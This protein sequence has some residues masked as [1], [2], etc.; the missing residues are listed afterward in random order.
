MFQ[1]RAWANVLSLPETHS[2]GWHIPMFQVRAWANVLSL[3]ETHSTVTAGQDDTQQCL[4][5]WQW[6]NVLSLPETHSTVTAGQDD[7]QQCLKYWQWA[8]VLSLPETHSTVTAGQDDTQQCLKYWQWANVL[9]LPE[10][11]STVTAGQD[12]TQQ[13]L[14]YW[15][16]ANVLSLPE[17]HSTVTAGQDDTQQCLK[18]WQWA[19]VL[20]LP[21]T[22]STVTAGQDDTQQCLKYWQWANVLSLPE[23]QSAVTAR[24][25]RSC[26]EVYLKHIQQD[27]T[28]QC[29]K[30]RW[31]NLL[32]L[33]ET[34]SAGQ[35]IAM[36]QVPAWVNVLSL[37]ETQSAVTARR[38]RSCS[39]VYLKHS[40]QWLPE[41]IEVVLKFTWNTVSSDCQKV[42][43]LFWSLP[44]T[45][46]A[47]TARRYRSCS[48][49]YLKH[50]QQWPNVFTSTVSSTGV[51][52]FIEFTWNTVSSD[53]MY[54]RPLF[55][56][57]EWADSLSLPET[58]SAVTECIYVHCFKYWS[59]LIHWVYLKHSQQWL[60][61]G[62]EV[63][64]KFT[65]NTVS[66]DCQKVSKLLRGVS[67][68]KLNLPP[69]SCIPSKAKMTMNR[70]SSSNKLAMERIL[71]SKDAT[72]LRRDDQYL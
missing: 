1:V 6:A 14:K 69:N 64:L 41:G 42:S 71:F 68:S 48:E 20:S 33:P 37:P 50:S 25:Y 24:R 13:C 26:S 11:H 58:Q 17:T 5:Y 18:Y 45:Q 70:K 52:W 60:P 31:T 59:G 3:P 8:N 10:T 57:L 22:H 16:W 54:L 51:G 65:W 61:E 47:V 43:K 2:T 38:Y 15:Q 66:S 12:D 21:E 35:H 62:I 46:S 7:T 53:R 49:V 30:Y 67:S 23:T 28:Y 44:E 72:R 63:A 40:Q 19:N 32:S 27:N 39:E 56:V 4:K 34:Q 36:F 29:V 9:S 55:Q